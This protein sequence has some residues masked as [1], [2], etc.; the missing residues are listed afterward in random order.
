MSIYA[1][2][3][4]LPSRSYSVLSESKQSPADAMI[5]KAIVHLSGIKILE[6]D[7]LDMRDLNDRDDRVAWLDI[8]AQD[9]EINT[10]LIFGAMKAAPHE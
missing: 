3:P 4:G 7:R 5:A 6:L 10:P 9:G 1:A 2:Y 8:L